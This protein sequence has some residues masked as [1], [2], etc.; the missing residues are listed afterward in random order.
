MV[1]RGTVASKMAA[2]PESIACSP[3][4]I[5]KNGMATLLMPRMMKM[6]QPLKGAELDDAE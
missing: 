2:T 1:N 6:I 5:R 4:E 3:H